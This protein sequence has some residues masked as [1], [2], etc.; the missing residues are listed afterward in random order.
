MPARAYDKVRSLVERLGG[1][2]TYVRQGYRYGAWL[3]SIGGRCAT[4]EASGHRSFLKLD[5]LYVPRV[6][7]PQTWDDYADEL[8]PDAEARLLAILEASG[9]APASGPDAEPEELAQVIART[10]WKFAW[11][12]AR[13]FPHEYTTRDRCR[14]ED[15]AR[16]VDC[17]ERYGVIERFGNTSRKYWHFQERKYWHMGDPHSADPAE[18]PNVINRSW[19]D[20]RR[21][22]E[23]VRH[24]WTPEEVDLQMRLWEIQLEKAAGRARQDKV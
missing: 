5:Q 18:W 17:I 20:V 16:L 23:N 9:D 22:A 13:T 8:L 4:V 10:A 1:T 19:E 21:H 3:I 14:P 15:H 2:M 7:A 6:S 24:R 12:Y 11:T